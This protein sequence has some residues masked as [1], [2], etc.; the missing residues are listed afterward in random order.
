MD[1]IH[2]L[3]DMQSLA[4][5]VWTPSSRHHPGQLSWS[6]Y[7]GEH[8]ELGPVEVMRSGGE[9]VAWAWAESDTWLEL[10]VDPAR[11]EVVDDLVAWFVDRAPEGDLGAMVLQTEQHLLEP[12]P[13][14]GFA[15]ADR[16]WFTH[17]FRDLAGLRVP[18]VAGYTFRHV[19]PS[20]AAPRAECHRAAW[21]AS[22]PSR[23]STTA[24]DALMHAPY[25]RPELDWV[26]VDGEG[27]MVASACL[28][29]DPAT[30]VVLVEP[31][32]CAPHHRGRGL[33]GAVS[34]AALC[35]AR[36]L[37]ATSALVCPRG[38]DD[39]PVPGRI[40]RSI[41]FRPGPRTITL[42]RPH[43]TG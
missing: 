6:V 20:E 33:A 23:V 21:S 10:C 31:V 16:P 18:D 17:H 30:R 26:A 43:R 12:L 27:A 34:L 25:Y 5:R 28:W 36:D 32:G 14:A 15:R 3:P 19:E 42:S 39:Y 22:G 29:L 4:S 38:D 9:V 2:A 41:G 35:A 40:Y 1:V 24:Y 13:A 37:G 7:Y 11:R 8:L